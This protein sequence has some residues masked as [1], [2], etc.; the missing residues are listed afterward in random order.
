MTTRIGPCRVCPRTV[1]LVA[2]SLAAVAAPR[3]AEAQEQPNVHGHVRSADGRPVPAA[4]VVLR[5]PDG[6][7]REKGVT[8]DDGRFRPGRVPPGQYV[9]VASRLGLAARARALGGARRQ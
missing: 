9:P 6:P 8:D 1:A 3:T 2:W 5:V 7:E 4:F